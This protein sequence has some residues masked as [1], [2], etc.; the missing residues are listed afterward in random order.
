M[1]SLLRSLAVVGVG[2]VGMKCSAKSPVVKSDGDAYPHDEFYGTWKITSA[3][4]EGSTKDAV[5]LLFR[6]DGSYTALD[7]ERKELWGGTFDLDPAAVQKRW[8]HR[9]YEAMK[10]GGDALGIYD[11]R[12]DELK[13]CCVVGKWEEAEWSGKPRPSTFSLPEADAVL[14]LQREKEKR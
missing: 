11:V 7:G 3:L 8:D 14:K 9:S 13:L 4:P 5:Y 12:G 6:E 1:K 10:D 2:L